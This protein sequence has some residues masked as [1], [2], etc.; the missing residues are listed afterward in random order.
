MCEV[1]ALVQVS[2]STSRLDSV[3]FQNGTHVIHVSVEVTPLSHLDVGADHQ[4][5]V[6][7]AD[8]PWKHRLSKSQCYTSV[9]SSQLTWTSFF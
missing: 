3:L 7:V 8:G 5:A 2:N 1:L 4:G 6:A 9:D